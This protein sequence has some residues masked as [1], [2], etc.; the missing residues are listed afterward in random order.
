MPIAHP[1]RSQTTR[2]SITTHILVILHLGFQNQPAWI[3]FGIKYSG[4]NNLMQAVYSACRR[5]CQLHMAHIL[6]WQ[7]CIWDSIAL[8]MVRFALQNAMGL[9]KLH[10]A[11]H[12]PGTSSQ[13]GITE[14]MWALMQPDRTCLIVFIPHGKLDGHLTAGGGRRGAS[15]ESES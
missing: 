3:L 10:T 11:C 6:A 13:G 14:V 1:V 9:D 5:F 12:N 15:T 2:P 4:P 8:E 7:Q